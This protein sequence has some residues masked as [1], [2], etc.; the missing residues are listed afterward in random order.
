MGW[1]SLEEQENRAKETERRLVI[2]IGLLKKTQKTFSIWE[3]FRED[4]GHKETI[5]RLEKQLETFQ[6]ENVDLLI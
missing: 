3:G 1:D 5:L 6:T 4:E 2:K